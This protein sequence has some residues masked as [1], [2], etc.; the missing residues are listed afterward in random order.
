MNSDLQPGD[1]IDDRFRIV[2]SLGAGGTASVFLAEDPTLS[3]RVAVKVLH[4]QL[5]DRSELLQRFQREAIALTTL[6]H[7]GL[8][9][10][11]RFGFLAHTPYL[12]TEW[13]EG[14]SLREFLEQHAPLS[15]AEATRILIP[16]TEALSHAHASGVVHRDL[17]P[18]NLL[19]RQTASGEQQPVI[20]DFGLCRSEQ[21]LTAGEVTLTQE[22][23]TLGTPSYMSPEQCLGKKAD[24]RT[25]IYALGCIFFELLT[26][27]R[28]FTG[29]TSGLVLLAHLNQSPSRLK[30]LD[31]Q[32]RMPELAQT[33]LDRC[34]A[35]DK[36]KRYQST[37]TLLTDLRAL[38]ALRNTSKMRRERIEASS[39]SSDRSRVAAGTAI[40]ARRTALPFLAGGAS[41]L[42]AMSAGLL[43]LTDSGN[44]LVFEEVERRLEPNQT[45]QVIQQ[46]LTI[47]KTLRGP[48]AAYQVA[49]KTANCAPLSHW[50]CA[51]RLALDHNLIALFNGDKQ[52]QLSLK[53]SMLEHALAYLS[54]DEGSTPACGT[55]LVKLVDDFVHDP[56][57]SG[58]TWAALNKIAVRYRG[59]HA[60]SSDGWAALCRLY[61][62]ST[63]KVLGDRIDMSE[64]SEVCR[65]LIG[66]CMSHRA[67]GRDIFRDDN[68]WEDTLRRTSALAYRLKNL[69]RA[70][71]AEIELAHFCLYKNR[72]EEA[73]R[74]LEKAHK[75]EKLVGLSDGEQYNL[76]EA[77]A[78]LSAK[79]TP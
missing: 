52:A 40:R 65:A 79:L 15:C 30:D 20:I 32:A 27:R 74:H 38:A 62:E 44:M 48:H 72:I 70:G 23:L 6:E 16:L 17:K 22:G 64:A 4:A 58:Q 75:L 5:S 2:S 35:K 41:L 10:V 31:A 53:I 63:M 37:P 55:T 47:I 13:I 54:N 50:S 43:L 24:A 66:T 11:Y 76:Q 8:L 14:Q 29:E 77:H 33:I 21:P 42:L 56:S 28:L 19:L 1:L 60:A 59:D 71:W 51:D 68:D 45:A 3:R 73:K 69:K 25:D 7:P 36:E 67:G 39:Q 49:V 12:V 9:K 18:E 34:L 61:G 26:G 78:A 57:L 46:G